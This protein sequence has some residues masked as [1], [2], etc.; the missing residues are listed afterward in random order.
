MKTRLN[1]IILDSYEINKPKRFGYYVAW[2][3]VVR[4]EMYDMERKQAIPEDFY[5]VIASTNFNEKKS[6]GIEIFMRQEELDLLE[7]V[8]LVNARLSDF[9]PKTWD[10]FY[11]FM[12]KNF[13]YDD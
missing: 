6:K 4:V 2:L 8:N 5:W 9:E 10:E 13:T 7:I 12:S 11:A 3:A 1:R